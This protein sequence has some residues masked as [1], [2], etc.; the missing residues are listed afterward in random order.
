[1]LLLLAAGA[2]LAAQP[3][4][5]PLKLGVV[6]FYN[7]RL[8]Y[9]K[10]QPFV[11]YLT[12]STGTTWELAISGSYERTVAA[13]CT[14]GVAL[15][16]LGPFTYLRAQQRCGATVLARLA[17]GGRA[18]YTSW[19]MVR[20][21]SPIRSLADLAGKRFAFGAP[22]STSS[23]LV[24]RG[25]LLDAGLRPG[26]DVICQYLQHHERAARAVLLGQAEACGVR[27]IMGRKFAERGLR[28]LA[29]SAPIP[30]F[31]LVLSPRASEGLR[32]TLWEVLVERP[33]RDAAM[34]SRMAAWD[35][36]LASGFA[37]ATASD[38]LA[39]RDLA[40]RVFGTGALARPE[41]D[42]VCATWAP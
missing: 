1:M 38:Y 5:T 2:P 11:D 6:S 40:E 39:L 18:N 9:L 19:I 25:M 3:R 8:M 4:A 30:N 33:K 31:P 15:A 12:S 29:E 20:R 17:T 37:P 16:Y 23:H 32:Q 22:L 27:D 34:A 14:G 28:I 41:E 7:P 26:E 42:L 21:D 24:P 13:L 35:E 36:E 10:Y